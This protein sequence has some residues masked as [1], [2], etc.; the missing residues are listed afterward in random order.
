MLHRTAHGAARPNPFGVQAHRLG[1]Q[2]GRS[3][4]PPGGWRSIRF[5]QCPG[6]WHFCGDR[7]QSGAELVRVKGLSHKVG[8]TKFEQILHRG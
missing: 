7:Q 3:R 4:V 1:R 2:P 8:K 6:A 5:A